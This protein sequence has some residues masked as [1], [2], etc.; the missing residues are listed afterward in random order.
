MHSFE[1]G[2]NAVV[3]TLVVR[4]RMARW[5]EF[6]RRFPVYVY[7]V[8]GLDT[9]EGGTP[10]GSAMGVVAGVMDRPRPSQTQGVP[11]VGKLS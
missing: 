4:G 1:S 5:G 9:F 3:W 10:R 2:H 8:R 7:P 6:E 11:P